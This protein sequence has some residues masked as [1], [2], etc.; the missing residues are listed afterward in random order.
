MP[1]ER[2]DRLAASLPVLLLMALACMTV[3]VPVW[4][5]RV[6]A[7]RLEPAGG[8]REPALWTF[9][10]SF[11]CICVWY[12]AQF[13]FGALLMPVIR[14]VWGI[15]GLAL[16]AQVFATLTGCAFGFYVVRRVIGQPAATLGLAGARPSSYRGAVAVLLL[17]F[18]SIEVIAALWMIVLHFVAGLDPE[19]QAPVQ[20]FA[21]YL[22][23]GDIGS[24]VF[25]AL[26]GVIVAPLG[27]EF[28][29]R[30]VVHTLLR[31]RWGAAAGTIA[32]SAIFAGAHLSLAG[33]VPLWVLGAL[34]ARVYDRSGSL[35]PAML[36]HAAF[37]GIS[38]ACIGLGSLAV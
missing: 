23:R 22:R 26:A 28:L 11:L 36:F 25:L 33:F 18:P 12:I 24:M 29:F 30:G 1:P 2:I 35:Y 27:E 37:N 17:S 13:F 14:P 6:P 9:A 20:E 38:L 19:T 31:D 15:A 32:S 8:R 10:E 7:V 4:R 16:V 3:L 21:Q 5:S 34:L